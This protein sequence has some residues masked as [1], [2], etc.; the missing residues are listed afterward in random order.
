MIARMIGR[1]AIGERPGTP[2]AGITPQAASVRTRASTAERG[3]R[4]RKFLKVR[5]A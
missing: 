1:I 5:T 4:D 2:A 3:S